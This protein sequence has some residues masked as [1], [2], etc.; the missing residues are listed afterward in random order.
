LWLGQGENAGRAPE[1]D[2]PLGCATHQ[3]ASEGLEETNAAAR[4]IDERRQARELR[5]FLE[6]VLGR[7]VHLTVTDN[8]ATMMTSK[9]RR[10]AMELRLHHM[11]LVAPQAIWDALALYLYDGNAAAGR[12]VD[13]FIDEHLHMVRR[14]PTAIRS[15]GRTHDL[16]RIL[17]E[18]NE[19]FFHGASRAKITWGRAGSRRYRRSIQLGS[20]IAQD[21]LIR[22]HPCLDQSFVPEFYVAW[23]VF[24]EMLHEA[25]GVEE[26]NGRRHIH[27]PAFVALE[28]SYPDYARAKA[29]EVRNLP[30]L[31]RY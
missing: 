19:R 24:H 27:P 8:R 4:P 23:V 20:Y 18:L 25:F 28:E 5:R 10:G 21:D 30:R 15:R 31:L 16:G 7:A 26:R 1:D 2:A 13:A 14:E 22:I 29:W 12:R 17:A 9:L 3:P 11:F 6:A